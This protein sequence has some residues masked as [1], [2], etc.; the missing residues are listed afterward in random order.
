MAGYLIGEEGPLTGFVARFEEEEEWVLGRD[1]EVASIVLE[2][3]L[4]SRRHVVCRHTEEGY[5]LENVSTTNPAL[6]NGQILI[7]PVLLQEGDL[8]KIGS[9]VFKFS[10][11]YPNLETED[12]KDDT[13]LINVRI[14]SGSLGRFIIKVTNGP[15][16]GAEFSM[17]K[18]AS[19]VLG[20]DPNLC[21]IAFQD[22]SVSRQHARIS[23]DDNNQVFIEDLS[24]RNGVLVNG[25]AITSKHLLSSEDLISLGTTSFLLI[26]REQIQETIF[27][28]LPLATSIKT[29]ELKQ[30]ES[31]ASDWREMI[32]PKKHLI[33]A[34]AFGIL[35]L[36]GITSMITLFKTHKIEVVSQKE[37]HKI[38]KEN[39]SAF[40]DVQFSFNPPS[41][42]LFLLGHVISSVE[43]QE[44][45]Y[46]IENLPFVHSIEDNV[47]VDE[48]IWENTNALLLTNPNWIGVSLSSIAP[49]KF[50]LRGYVQ[51][52]EQ[53]QALS[54]YLNLNF[55]YLDRLE[56][57]VIVETNLQMQVESI[58][59]EKGFNSV[60]YQLSNGELVLAGRVDQKKAHTFNATIDQFYTVPGIRLIK[61]FVIYTKADTSRIDISSKYQITG[62]SKKDDQNMFVVINGKIL[63]IE[64]MIDGMKITEI[65][66]NMVLLE[67][68]GVK[69]R[70]NYNL[71]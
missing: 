29:E 46:K 55:P 33:V 23:I 70:I 53:A 71:Q 10:H 48:L 25:I 36:A 59:I 35:V 28:P 41:G 32:I 20:K 13:D 52:L 56:N 38:L 11:S 21:D 43:K 42:K 30:E 7:E 63:T 69:F 39:L 26:D 14:G 2:D 22:L 60:T 19:Y 62:Y 18:G 12:L 65:L 47:I 67:K 54:D 34:S 61:N 66:S 24:S 15:N 64:D 1:P 8:I 3:P 17:Q 50:V 5:V 49:G 68:D 40:P 6:V 16:A 44:L 57:Q 27:S 4:V 9:S 58:L 31:P 51:T 45:L 37:E